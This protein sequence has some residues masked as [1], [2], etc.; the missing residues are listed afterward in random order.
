[1][2]IPQGYLDFLREFGDNTYKPFNIKTSHD[3]ASP[4]ELLAELE[5]QGLLRV[6]IGMVEMLDSK[7]SW[8]ITVR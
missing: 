7:F 6:D 2:K 1:V 5:A 4:D 8:H 3:Y